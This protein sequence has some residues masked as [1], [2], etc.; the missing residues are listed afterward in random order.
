MGGEAANLSVQILQLALIHGLDVG[1]RIAS[2]KHV[3][4]PLEGG[5]LPVT[6]DG[7]VNAIFRRELSNGFGF[8][9]QLQHNLGFEGGSVRFFHAAILPNA[10]V[11]TVQILGSTII[12]DVA[13]QLVGSDTTL[14]II[15]VG[16]MNNIARSLGIPFFPEQVCELIALGMTRDIDMGQVMIPGQPER[17][18]FFESAGVGLSAVAIPAGDMA[19]SGLW[20][21]LP[22]A[23]RQMYDSHPEPIRTEFDDGRI[24]EAPSLLVTISN[25]PL[26]GSNIVMAP[27]A[28]MD[29][30]LLDIAVYEGMTKAELLSHFI[31]ANGRRFDNPRVKFHHARRV[32]I[33]APQPLP[34]HSDAGALGTHQTVEIE[35]KPACLS[36][37]VGKG[38][39][40]TVPV[41]T[42]PEP[43]PLSGSQFHDPELEQRAHD[44]V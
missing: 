42:A 16:T 18:S 35:L 12:K 29:D 4:Q 9:Q 25:A 27:G 23:L 40:L 31:A 28:Q 14:G 20:N 19:K 33:D 17:I 5:L 3:R 44:A 8:L 11:L 32:R 34:I 7:G 1:Q 15:P 6:Q 24:L 36:V 30:G 43:P 10:G 37:M 38:I 41:E 21:S 39:G 26:I 2:L 13:V 22:E